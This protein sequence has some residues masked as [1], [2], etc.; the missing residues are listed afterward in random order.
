MANER[1]EVKRARITSIAILISLFAQPSYCKDIEFFFGSEFTFSNNTIGK[2]YNPAWEDQSY[3]QIYRHE[4]ARLA[5]YENEQNNAYNALIDELLKICP[6]CKLKNQHVITNVIFPD[7][8]VISVNVDPGVIET[9]AYPATVKQ[10]KTL[11]KQHFEN[12]FLG[13]ANAGLFPDTFMS[14]GHIHIGLSEFLA[15]PILFRNF[16]VDITNHFELAGGILDLNQKNAPSIQESTDGRRRLDKFK[17]MIEAFDN[18]TL[19]ANSWAFSN[20]GE[21]IK[22]VTDLAKYYFHEIQE[23]KRYFALNLQN[24]HGTLEI[25]AI[26]A[27]LNFEE[28]LKE[29][30]LFQSRLNYLKRLSDKNILIPVED[31]VDS[32]AL[33][34]KKYDKLLVQKFYDYVTESGLNWAE[35]KPLIYLTD[36]RR[37]KIIEKSSARM[38]KNVL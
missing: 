35:Y 26:H 36:L 1:Y 13:A 31:F 9:Q 29:I 23:L 10:Y 38:C 32:G 37:K 21:V 25:R 8:Y 19:I 11:Y 22:S 2:L 6:S 27:Q 18:G 28:Y 17:S 14:G 3:S 5:K 7:T 15:E 34:T 30:T 12:L 4:S 24:K 20:E 33:G 16:I